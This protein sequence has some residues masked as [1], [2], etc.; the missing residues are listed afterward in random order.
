MRYKFAD[1]LAQ[2]Y[3]NDLRPVIAVY[4]YYNERAKNYLQLSKDCESNEE[5]ELREE[6]LL[7]YR[8]YRAVTKRLSPIISDSQYSIKWLETAKQP[9]S[10]REIS[11]RSRYQRT[12]LWSD[13]DRLTMYDLRENYSELTVEELTR[14]KDY[15]E[16]LS[17]RER[18]AIIS[19]IGQGNTYDQTASYLGVSR[20]TAQSYVNRGM[21]KINEL[22]INGAQIHLF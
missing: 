16:C 15:M 5:W 13:M 3:K 1:E 12:E 4:S 22:I 20:S 6:F 17:N 14:L 11:R 7:L 18:E 9:N 21:K 10:R 2:E 8:E 19:V